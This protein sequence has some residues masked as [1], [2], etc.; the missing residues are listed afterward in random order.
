MSFGF[1]HGLPREADMVM[2]LRFLKNPHWE[3]ELKPQTGLDQPVGDYIQ[4]DEAFAPFIENFK[5]MIL[6]LLPRYAEEGKSYLTI[7]LGCTGGRHRSV[8]TTQTLSSWIQEQGYNTNVF[9][10]DIDR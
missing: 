6:P 8:F 2:D 3:P 9:H 4:T 7:A 5:K 1:K 10:R